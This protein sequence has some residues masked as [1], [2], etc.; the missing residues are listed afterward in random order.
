VTILRYNSE[1]GFGSRRLIDVWWG[2]L[3]NNGGLMLILSYL[4]Q[5]SLEWRGAVVRIKMVV[6][7]EN[8]VPAAKKNLG[9][10][11]RQSRTGGVPE[12][13]V[14]DGRPFDQILHESSRP[15]DLVLLGF[16][17]PGEGFTAYYDDIMD[18]T[19]GLPT[20]LFVLAAEDLA[21]KEV[22]LESIDER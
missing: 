18:R 20:T 17:E 6:P 10:I 12:I 16:A 1:K 3:K 8:A 21:F 13:I 7:N 19:A 9:A 4:L 5:T 22:L 2:G 15:A 11:I 14:A